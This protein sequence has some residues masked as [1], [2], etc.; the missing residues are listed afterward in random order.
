[1]LREKPISV[2]L[3]IKASPVTCIALGIPLGWHK[4]TLYPTFN[5]VKSSRPIIPFIEEL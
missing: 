4:H 5:L 2:L 1:M 3:M